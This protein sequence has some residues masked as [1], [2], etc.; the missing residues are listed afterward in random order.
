M[1]EVSRRLGAFALVLAGTFG[2]AYAL[3]E[4]LPGHQHVHAVSSTTSHRLQVE[5]DGSFVV[6]TKGGRAVTS[7]DVVHEALLHVI[8]VRP[9][10]T[11][12]QHLHPVIGTDGHFSLTLDDPGPWVV[13]AEGTDASS[14]QAFLTRADLGTNLPFTPTDP[15]PVVT[16]AVLTLT[17]GERA[18]ITRDGLNFT[19]DA[20]SPLETY[21]GEP[22]HLVA[23]RMGD[24][25][26]FHMHGVQ[27]GNTLSFSPPLTEDGTYRAYLQFGYRGDVVTMPFTIT[28][29]GGTI[30]TLAPPP[31]GIPVV[32]H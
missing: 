12:F 32:H 7:F 20:P 31:K 26:F 28:V 18:E 8:V 15:S 25:A 23:L 2:T 17:G 11:G 1:G 10:G 3:G 9:D 19:I 16:A 27:S 30:P 22:G 6:E 29:S 24:L 5:P 13:F 21:L 14:N 4:K